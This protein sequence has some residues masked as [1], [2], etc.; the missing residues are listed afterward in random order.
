MSVPGL[1]GR[2][3]SALA[4]ATEKRGSTTMMLAAWPI[5]STSISSCPRALSYGYVRP[6]ASAMRLTLR[7]SAVCG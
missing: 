3:Y 5:A 1:I 7:Q 4:A 2:Y 6:S